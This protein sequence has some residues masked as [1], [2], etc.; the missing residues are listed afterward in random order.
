MW[1]AVE[2]RIGEDAPSFM[3]QQIAASGR[4]LVV[5]KIE[6]REAELLHCGQANP[7]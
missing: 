7:E 4:P 5:A 6:P 1:A 3:Q 2:V